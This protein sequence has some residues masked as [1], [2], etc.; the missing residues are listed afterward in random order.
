MHYNITYYNI[1]SIGFTTYLIPAEIFPTRV[2]ILILIIMIRKLDRHIK[3][4]LYYYY[5]K[6]NYNI[7]TTMT[8]FY[9]V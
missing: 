2:R 6:H 9:Y 3:L 7:H 5:D 1:D 4:L 8:I